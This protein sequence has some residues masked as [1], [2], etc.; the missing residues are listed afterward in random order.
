M[1]D[2]SKRSFGTTPGGKAYLYTLRAGPDFSVQITNYGGIIVALETPDR[3]GQ[4]ADIVLGFEDLDN[5][6]AK[7]PHFGALVGR[8]GNRIAQGAF[9]LDGKEYTLATNDGP[10]HLHGG[11]HG[12]DK[13]LWHADSLRTDDAVGLKLTHISPDGDEGYPGNLACRVTYWVTADKTLAIEYE[14]QTDAPTHVNLTNHSYFNLAGHDARKILDHL[15]TIPADFFVPV[16]ETMIP[17]GELAPLADTPFDFREPHLIGE[18]IDDDHPQLLYGVGYDHTFVVDPDDQGEL[19]LAARVS[20]PTTGRVLEVWSTE[21]GVQLYTGNFLDG[22]VTGKN[23]RIYKYRHG[24]CLETQ[25]FPDTP[26][27]P[28][29]PSTLLQPEEVFHSRTEFRFSSE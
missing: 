13:V 2:I 21:P 3:D 11:V 26:N 18:H 10:N 5:Y 17:T 4:L 29:F 23:R 14:A 1:L 15:L 6:V 22:T 25:H 24:F 16:D 20:E 27:Q 9:T 7:H 12:F 8:Y 19:R 28:D